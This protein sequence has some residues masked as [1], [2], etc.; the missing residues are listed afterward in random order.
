MT[1]HRLESALAGW[2]AAHRLDEQERIRMRTEILLTPQVDAAWWA[3]FE[4]RMQRTASR[5]AATGGS[6]RRWAGRAT[7][8]PVPLAWG[9]RT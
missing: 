7:A 8:M 4:A 1:D 9:A 6:G 5:V 3:R 2:V